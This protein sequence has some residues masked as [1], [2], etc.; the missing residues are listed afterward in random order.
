MKAS[1]AQQAELWGVFSLL[2]IIH[3]Q[4]CSP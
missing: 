3:V 1:R 4:G 2:Q